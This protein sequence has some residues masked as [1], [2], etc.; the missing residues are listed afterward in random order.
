MVA[1][2]FKRPAAAS[3]SLETH[4]SSTQLLH[5]RTKHALWGAWKLDLGLTQLPLTPPE[6]AGVCRTFLLSSLA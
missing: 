1:L 5:Q 2:D 6:G 4:Q 3:W